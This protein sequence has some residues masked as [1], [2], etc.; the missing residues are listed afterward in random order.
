MKEKENS[1]AFNAWWSQ[2]SAHA[3]QS[4]DQNERAGRFAFTEWY[5]TLPPDQRAQYQE[6]DRKRE[7]ASL[8][9]KDQMQQGVVQEQLILP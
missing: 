8:L 1:S 9:F 3:Q 2:L 6:V 7:K 5:R 4:Y